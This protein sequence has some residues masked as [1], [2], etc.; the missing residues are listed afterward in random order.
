VRNEIK[1]GSDWIKILATGAFMTSSTGPKDSP[2]N[3]HMS[4]EEIETCVI[5]AKRRQVRVMAHAHGAEGIA[6]AANSGVRSIEHASFIDD[7]GVEAC[8]RNNTW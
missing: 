5:E 2:E 4:T 7:I 3:T 1:Y 8:L 6:I